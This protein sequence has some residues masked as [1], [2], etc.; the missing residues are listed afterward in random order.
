MNKRTDERTALLDIEI[1]LYRNAAKAEA[2]GTQLK[3]LIHMCM[4]SIDRAVM[5]C[6]TSEFVLATSGR[7][8]FR[9]TLYPTYKANRGQKPELYQALHDH[10]KTVFSNKWYTHDQLEADDLLGIMATNGR[11]TNPIICS[12]DKDMLSVPG[13][14]YNWDK[15]SWPTFVSEEEAN[16][17]WLMQLLMGDSTDCIE[18][19]KGIGKAKAK[20][21]IEKYGISGDPAL[22]A[23]NIY[24]KEGFDLDAYYA[25]LNC[26]TIWRAPMPEALLENELIQ[27]VLK[28]IPSLNQ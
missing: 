10:I 13:W 23:K 25:C 28:T 5:A 7:R 8:N 11:V 17:N 16:Y 3:D 4:Q 18:G 6:K 21:L 15:D 12:I 19:M 26:V 20:K 22:D 9:K 24:E 2:E 14:H 1:L 27:E